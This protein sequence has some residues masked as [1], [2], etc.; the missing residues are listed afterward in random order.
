ME[1]FYRGVEQSAGSRSSVYSNDSYKRHTYSEYADSTTSTSSRPISFTPSYMNNAPQVPARKPVGSKR[2]P[3]DLKSAATALPPIELP[4]ARSP[5]SAPVPAPNHVVK[6]LLILAIAAKPHPSTLSYVEMILNRGSFL[7]IVIMGNA[8]QE[9]ELKELK[10]NI[11]ALLGKLGIEGGAH[12][13]LQKD[14]SAAN[15]TEIMS[16]AVKDTDPINGV[17]CTPS[18]DAGKSVDAEILS[19]DEDELQSPWKFS[20][21]F[22]HSIAK[23]TLPRM[24]PKRNTGR[25]NKLFFLVTEPKETTAISHLYETTCDNILTQ[26]SGSSNLSGI[27]IAYAQ[28]V[29]IPEP[30]PP[31]T[32]G[33]T[34]FSAKAGPIDPD[35]GDFAPGESPTR[36]W[37]MWAL[38]DE[39]GA[40]N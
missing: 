24:Q 39:L 13:E 7:G 6:G 15:I 16:K 3:S 1:R 25:A 22:L 20:V 38:Q 31:R 11:Y 33:N 21:G 36:L 18:Y 17:L 19:L 34:D 29:L 8:E 5:P 30:E 2:P 26:L 23:S 37:G 9:T 10:M 28:D 12:L 27:T 35:V 14:W 4:T 32:N 40:V